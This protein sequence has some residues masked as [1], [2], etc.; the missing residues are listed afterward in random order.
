MTKS[1]F[2]TA[3]LLPGL[4]LKEITGSIPDNAFNKDPN[5][6]PPVIVCLKHCDKSLK[7]IQGKKPVLL[8]TFTGG[9]EE[10][11]I[12]ET[13]DE[14]VTEDD[15]EIPEYVNPLEEVEEGKK[16]ESIYYVRFFLLLF[17]F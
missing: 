13:D 9:I 6:G 11:E 15:D 17:Q 2:D 4:K 7:F 1:I 8:A 3:L 16:N 5:A 14:S 12:E 10:E